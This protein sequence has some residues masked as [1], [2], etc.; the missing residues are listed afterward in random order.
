MKSD[1]RCADALV[2][3]AFGRVRGEGGP[4]PV[5][6]SSL[7]FFVASLVYAWERRRERV[8]LEVSCGLGG[9]LMDRGV[10]EEED[11]VVAGLELRTCFLPE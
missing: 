3:N 10:E 2:V 11:L 1:L 4:R 9:I 5:K 8:Y 6:T 7:R